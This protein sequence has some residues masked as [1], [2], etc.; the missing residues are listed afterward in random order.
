MRLGGEGILFLADIS[1]IFDFPPVFGGE[2]GNAGGVRGD[3]GGGALYLEIEKGRGLRGGEA[4]G[5]FFFSGS[6]PKFPPSL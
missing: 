4:G 2:G 1:N 5:S 3:K 6:G